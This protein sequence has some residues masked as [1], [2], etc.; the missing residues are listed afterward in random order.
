MRRTSRLF[1]SAVLAMV[2]FPAGVGR[3]EENASVY[4]PMGAPP[5]P[6]VSAAWNRYHDY[7][8]A[9]KLLRQLAETHS[10]RCRLVSLGKSYGGREMW[11]LTIA[12]FENGKET[13]KPA[14]WIDGGIHA[15]EI[16]GAE[17]ALYSA[18]YLLEMYGRNPAVTRLVDQRAF[19]IV[20]MMSPDSR[21][22]HMH[23]PNSTST[24]RGGQL[25]TDD[26][27]DGLADEDGPDDLDG[28]GN[29]TQ[30]RVRD[31]NG[32][33][34]PHP[35]FPNLMI[36]AEPDEKGQYTLLGEEGYDND[37]DGRVNED[38]EGGYDPNRDW[39]WNW[40]PDYVQNGARDYPLALQENRAVA[41]F[42]IAHPN[43]AGAQSYH[44]SGGMILYGPGGKEDHFDPADT[45]VYKAIAKKGELMLPGYRGMNIGAELYEVFGGELDWLHAMQGVFGFTN[46]MFPA[47]NLFRRPSE[48]G[49]MGK[50]EDL[51][52]FDKYLLLGEGVVPWHE[53]NHP[54][55]G[56]IE[57]GGL[58]KEW[59]RQPPS[60]LLE[61]ECHRN[62]AFTLY[63]ADQMP[64]VRVDS[65]HA[66][67]LSTGLVE[68]T[69]VVAND[70]LIPTHAAADV[71]NHLTRPDLVLIS[72]EKLEVLGGMTS[73]EPFFRRPK[74][75]K[76]KPQEMRVGTI[77][78]MGAVYVRWI[79]HGRGPYTV[80]V[81]SPKGG[82]ATGSGE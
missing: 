44:N 27:R 35:D 80:T 10:A 34:K 56:K 63:H 49:F 47:F 55:F 2:L 66:R 39:P 59:V 54:Q 67:P 4:N 76:R 14:F 53:V 7:A 45:A 52:Q 33:W 3:A 29:I 82:V 26:D 62:M 81:R 19:Y 69:A 61:E 37:G 25:P 24:P 65:I 21:D 40:Q 74:D 48:G 36:Q 58:K 79:V 71:K 6:K 57:V 5:D 16:Q 11:L 77:P 30:M 9:T 51:H 20:P 28:D 18:W 43:I 70:R 68:V 42:I 41:D 50:A 75:Q 15:N 22:A 73:D 78:G 38:P 12:N 60:F 17:A 72:G 46:E 31:P 64:K 8:D 1:S 13:E 32:R 23:K